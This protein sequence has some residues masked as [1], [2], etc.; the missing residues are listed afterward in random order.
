[1][2]VFKKLIVCLL[3]LALVLCLTACGGDKG[4]DVDIEALATDLVGSAAFVSDMSQ[5]QVASAAAAGSYG[6]S[7]DD[8]EKCIMYYN[9]AE[10]EELFLAKTVDGKADN[11]KTLCQ[12]RVQNQKTSLQSYVPAAIPRL[13]SAIIQTTG[14]YVIFVVADNAAAAQTIID[15]YLK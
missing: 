15:G 12:N 7:T 14:N 2:R 1:M 13:D 8:V 3:I 11:L 4:K 9:G 5:Y 10:G 6:F